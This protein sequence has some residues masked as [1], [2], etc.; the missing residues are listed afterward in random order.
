MPK[1]L[2]PAMLITASAC[3]GGG[4]DP[5]T[6]VDGTTPANTLQVTMLDYAFGVAGEASAGEVVV[7]FTN[8]G[9]ELHH[10]IIGRLDQGKTLED[11]QKF[12]EKGDQ[13]PPPPWFD[14]APSDMTL[15]SP[16]KTAGV[17]IDAEEGTYAV[18]CFMPDPKGK[19]HVTRGMFQ[20]FE[21]AAGEAAP[22]DPNA[23]ITMT[24]DGPEAPSLTSGHSLVEVTNE[25][26]KPGEVFVVQLAKGKTLD[27]IEA[28]FQK[29][30]KGAAPATFFGG[31]HQFGP[32]ESV[33]LSLTLDPGHYSIVASYGGGKNIRDLPTEF[34]VSG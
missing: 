14:D 23:Q 10:G 21:V 12:L 32:G 30:Q 20:T 17:V 4:G 11:V 22:A 7:D 15:V 34:T 27:D 33:T 3:G 19:P 28:W 9:K 16:G 2:I 25:A 18:L 13:G 29:G 8:G 5:T 24:Q 1:W 31:T 6:D 26:D